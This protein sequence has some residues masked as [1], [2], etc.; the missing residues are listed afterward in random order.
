MKLNLGTILT[1]VLMTVAGRL[2]AALG[3]STV[4]YIGLNE[5]QKRIVSAV[6]QNID[7]LPK[8]AL[9]LIYIAGLR[10]C[11]NWIMGAFAF[12]ISLKSLSRL[13]AGISKK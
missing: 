10:I 12:V 13:S 11:L 7:S 6:A 3:V 1:S 5:I 8:E 4:S 9:Q 2:V